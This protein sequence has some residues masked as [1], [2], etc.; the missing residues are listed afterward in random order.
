[1]EGDGGGEGD[2]EGDG[3]VE[4]RDGRRGRIKREGKRRTATCVHVRILTHKQVNIARQKQTG[5]SKQA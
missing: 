5:K 2:E 1:M 3:G 4:K